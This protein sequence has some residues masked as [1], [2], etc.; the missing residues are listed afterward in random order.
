MANVSS[1]DVTI[2]TQAVLAKTL[3]AYIEAAQ[4]NAEYNIISE[5]SLVDVEIPTDPEAEVSISGWASGRW[6]YSGNLESYFAP[7]GQDNWRGDKEAVMAFYKLIGLMKRNPDSWFEINYKDH[8]GGA[9]FIDIGHMWVGGPNTL[10]EGVTIDS[11]T[12]SY[13]LENMMDI[14]GYNEWE[15]IDI[16]YGDEVNAAWQE[17]QT[18]GGTK[19]AQ[20]FIDDNLSEIYDGDFNAMEVVLEERRLAAEEEGGEA[21]K[22]A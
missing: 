20:E 15:A 7:P 10:E 18:A 22:T 19:P 2:T 4:G 17:Y 16:M 12:E 5:D 8:E 11:Q 3:F 14:F 1:A 21:E 13:D 6:S 9:G